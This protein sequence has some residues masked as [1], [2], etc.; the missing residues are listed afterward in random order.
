MGY[1]VNKGAPI[2]SLFLYSKIINFNLVDGDAHLSPRMILWIEYP[3][4][5]VDQQEALLSEPEDAIVEG[6][7]E[8]KN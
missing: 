6:E 8:D 4:N 2:P 1:N 5:A 3:Y 7:N